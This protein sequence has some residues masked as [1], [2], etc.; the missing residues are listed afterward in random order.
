MTMTFSVIGST[1]MQFMAQGVG[2]PGIIDINIVVLDATG[3]FVAAGF[4]QTPVFEAKNTT[5]TATATAMEFPTQGTALLTMSA[6][7]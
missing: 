2:P 5:Y 1:M 3:A 7:L 4:N 6:G